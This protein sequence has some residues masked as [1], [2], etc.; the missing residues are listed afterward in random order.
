[1]KPIWE[2]KMKMEGNVMWIILKWVIRKIGYKNVNRIY[3][4]YTMVY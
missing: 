3:L 2:T 4:D 1:M